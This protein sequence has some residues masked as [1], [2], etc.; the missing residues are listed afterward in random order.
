MERAQRALKVYKTLK[1]NHMSQEYTTLPR[2]REMGDKICL[3]SIEEKLQAD[4]K[5]TVEEEL[6]FIRCQLNI[7]TNILVDSTNE[8]KSKLFQPGVVNQPKNSKGVHTINEIYF[9]NEYE[10]KNK[11]FANF[12]VKLEGDETLYQ[13]DRLIPVKNPITVG[14]TIYCE[15]DNEKLRNVKVLQNS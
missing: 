1:E 4:E 10:Y 12:M 5:L 6:F 3:S 13:W 9:V 2:F 8:L 7:I 11:K 14:E 15:I